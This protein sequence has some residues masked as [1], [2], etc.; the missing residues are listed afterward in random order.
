MGE[1]GESRIVD[2][3]RGVEDW[4]EYWRGSRFERRKGEEERLCFAYWWLGG[5]YKYW[6]CTAAAW[7]LQRRILLIV[8][9]SLLALEEASM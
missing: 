8:W 4:R 7:D 6:L 1:L 9:F 5:M 2:E 3:I